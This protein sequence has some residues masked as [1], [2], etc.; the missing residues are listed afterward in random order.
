MYN[1]EIL[2]LCSNYAGAVT[3]G[4]EGDKA[5]QILNFDQEGTLNDLPE[6]LGKEYYYSCFELLLQL[7]INNYFLVIFLNNAYR[8]DF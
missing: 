6:S 8:G 5:V 2:L 4:Y 7:Y 3:D 1:V